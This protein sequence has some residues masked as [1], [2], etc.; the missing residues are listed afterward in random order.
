LAIVVGRVRDRPRDGRRSVPRLLLAFPRLILFMV[1]GWMLIAGIWNVDLSAALTALGVTSL[2]VSFALQDTLGG[3]A[4]GFTL[5]ADQPFQVGDWIRADTVEGRVVDI[6]WRSSRIQNRNGDLVIVPNGELADATIT[7]FDEPARLHRVV[8]PVQVAYANSPTNAKEMLL[9]A[10]RSTPGVLAEP[11]PA[12][13]VVQVDDPLMGYEVHLWIDDYTIT[14][15]VT[16]DFGSLVWY[17]SHRRGVPLPS[18]AQDLYLWDGQRTAD[19][20]RRDH[21]SVLVGLRHSPLLDQLD[22]DQLDQLAGATTPGRFSRG[23]TILTPDSQ[24]LVVLEEGTARYVL[25]LDDGRTETV[26][27]LSRGEVA[28]ALDRADTGGHD[29]ALVA[30]TDCDVLALPVDVAGGVISRSPEL[31]SALDQLASSRRRRVQRLLRRVAT[32]RLVADAD[33][34]D[35]ATDAPDTATGSTDDPAT[36]SPSDESAPR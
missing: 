21:G 27:E 2:V 24:D 26:L 29:I 22:D 19:S 15:Q 25:Q 30:T 35:T 36:S 18:P 20:G 5:L 34:Q 4:S 17:H 13:L 7:N 31:S 8:V 33:A 16:S 3:L 1:I 9:A 23:E 32:E 11:P 14:P 28:A 6:N 12:A 10:A